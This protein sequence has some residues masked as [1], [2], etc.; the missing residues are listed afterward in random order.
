MAMP[1]HLTTRQPAWT[2]PA[3][4]GGAV[5]VL[6]LLAAVPLSWWRALAFGPSLRERAAPAPVSDLRLL[7]LP[8]VAPPPPVAAAPAQDPP[9]RDLPD[10][11]AAW[12]RQA[13]DGRLAADL[14]PLRALP[15]SLLPPALVA[16]WGVRPTVELILATP[17]SAVA[18]R[19]WRLVESERLTRD[20]L[21][22]L[23][24]AIARAR[25]FQDLKSREAAMYGEFRFETV[26]VTK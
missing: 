19:L 9:P 1:A 15:D 4:L 12:W 11:D 3:S 22:G 7:E 17:D 26:P 18:A 24:T 21:D 10:Q 16:V 2:W 13:W 8:A 20:D 6:L 5:L 14:R 25:A 23:F